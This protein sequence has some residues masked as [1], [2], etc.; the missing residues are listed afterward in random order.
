MGNFRRFAFLTTIAT[1]LLIF[2]GGLVRVSGAGLGCPDWPKCF[3]RWIPPMNLYQLPANI[4][5]SAFN[6]T[7]AWIEYFNRLV[8][9]TIGILILITAI[10]AIKY[11]RH[12]KSIVYPSIAAALLVAYQGWQGSQIV[13][14]KLEPLIVSVHLVLALI[15]VSLLIYVTQK[16]Y[17]I[18][19]GN[20]SVNGLFPRKIGIEVA[21][22]WGATIL[23]IV[24]GTQV[25][26]AVENLQKSHPLSPDSTILGMIG[27][28]NYIHMIL[29]VL[30]IGF[31]FHIAHIIL[32]KSDEIPILVKQSV[33]GMVILMIAQLV[34]GF[35][36]IAVGMPA[37]TQV[38]H[39]WMA[40]LFVGLNLVLYT[41][42]RRTG[43]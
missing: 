24:F 15:I 32:K 2:I 37:L 35:L 1:Y 28:V 30:V 22:L 36:L 18:E 23:Q 33:Y 38:F 10:L 42:V 5:P 26:S 29:G 39:L 13:L 8:G 21:I 20:N 27:A 4:D 12:I 43:D 40:S 19:Q 17:Y 34:I 14:S 9:M 16:A 7:L 41:A 3:G 25:R 31:T 11:Y 6:F